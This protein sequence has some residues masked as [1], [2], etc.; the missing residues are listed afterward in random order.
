MRLTIVKDDNLVIIDKRPIRF[1]LSDYGLP[2]N[3]HALQWYG[4]DGEAEFNDGTANE[5]I[6]SLDVYAPIIE[7]Y[8]RLKAIED[9][10]PAPTEK[11]KYVGLVGQRNQYLNQTDWLTVRHSD[12][13]TSPDIDPTSLTESEFKKLL[14]WRQELREL[15]EM[16]KTSDAWQWPDPPAYLVPKYLAVYPPEKP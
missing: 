8:D 10:P 11:D 15:P 6:N 12:Q 4:N 9:N 14:V 3:F 13:A 1:D 2:E 5:P 16:Y 7:E